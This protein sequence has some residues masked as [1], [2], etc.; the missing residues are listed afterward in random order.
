MKHY[1]AI[2]SAAVL[3]A[4]C[5]SPTSRVELTSTERMQPGPAAISSA[6]TVESYKQDIAQRISQ[7]NSTHVHSQRPQALLRS[8]IVVRYTV[9]GE[10]RLLRSEIQRSNHDRDTEALALSTLRKTAPFPKPAPHLLHNGRLDLSESWLFD[11]DGR[12]QLRSIAQAQKN[13]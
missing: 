3:L 6:G 8:V 7:V 2:F 1:A 9:D 5:A 12:F 13:E 4:G 10:G 11:N